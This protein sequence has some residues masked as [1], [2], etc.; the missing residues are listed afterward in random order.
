[1]SAATNTA[2]PLTGGEKNDGAASTRPNPVALETPVTVTGARPSS[3]GTRDLFTE[4]TRTILV[5][6][7]G[8]VIQL[9]AGVSVGQLLFLTNQKTKEEVV[10]Q[11]LQKR[12]FRPTVCYVEVQFTEEK[13]NFWGVSFEKEK[14]GPVEFKVAEQVAAQ[15][16]TEDDG[17]GAVAPKSEQEIEELK[18][19][20]ESLREQL[21]ELEKR[22]AQDAASHELAPV[23]DPVPETQ[24]P[25]ATGSA[26]S[27]TDSVGA[28]K[29]PGG[30]ALLMPAAAPVEKKTPRWAVPMALPGRQKTAEEAAAERDPS[31]ELLPK[32]ELDFSHMPSAVHLDEND[33]R[34]I[35]KPKGIPPHR[36]RQIALVVALVG[37]LAFAGYMRAWTALPMVKSAASGVVQRA[38]ELVNKRGRTKTHANAPV[39]SATK[40]A[41]AAGVAPSKA[42][43]TN[44]E[45]VREAVGADAGSK[46]E[47]A[48]V[49]AGDTIVKPAPSD[50]AAS[51]A[52]APVETRE[53]P[54]VTKRREIARERASV[55]SRAPQAASAPEQK[56][57]ETVAPDGPIVAPK[58][59]HAAS[60]VYPPEAM[61]NYITGDVKAELVVGADGKVG[62]VKVISGPKALRDAAIEALKKYEYAPGTQGGRPVAT[63]TTATVKFWFNP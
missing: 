33:P 13:A 63:K 15:E 29:A 47:A 52:S 37:A 3:E 38:K 54:R 48:P 18:K 43:A 57:A 53:E 31:E 19:Q 26:A 34:S 61:W 12:V 46:G 17:G 4:E 8:A 14:A 51:T 5:F 49:P 42:G 44:P 58:L 23:N 2:P 36:V 1:M 30:E 25:R 32:P 24:A 59:V 11:I 21:Q 10:C 40:S 39:T 62:E 6:V 7:D 9:A 55:K 45:Q 56:V 50:A 20:V 16:T 27:G 35:Y 28:E 60:P 41:S 22:K